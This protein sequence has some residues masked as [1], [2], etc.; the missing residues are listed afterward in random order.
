VFSS[1]L[2]AVLCCCWCINSRYQSSISSAHRGYGQHATGCTR[3]VTANAVRIKCK[4]AASTSSR[5]QR[6]SG[7]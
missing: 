3:S 4:R 1:I 2:A 6:S 5:S 7:W